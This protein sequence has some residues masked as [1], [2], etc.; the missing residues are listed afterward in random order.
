MA[1]P[2]TL[3]PIGRSGGEPYFSLIVKPGILGGWSMVSL[4]IG[5]KEGIA[6]F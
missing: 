2:M 5:M 4:R 3:N 1:I 6:G